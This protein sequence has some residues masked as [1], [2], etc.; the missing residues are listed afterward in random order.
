MS[1]IIQPR[2]MITKYP[3][4]M[5]VLQTEVGV[6]AAFR[7]G[8]D[9]STTIEMFNGLWDTGATGSAISKIVVDQLGLKPISK[10]KVFNVHGSKDCDVFLI[11][12]ILPSGIS[13]N[14]LSA[15]EGNFGDGIGVLIGMDVISKGD[16]SIS[17]FSNKTTFSFRIPS[18]EHIEL[19][20]NP[21][22]PIAPKT[23]ELYPGTLPN[24]RCPCKSGKK[25][26]NCCKTTSPVVAF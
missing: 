4:I 16:F 19:Q 24:N 5:R 12:V 20:S 3:A 23:I 2:S 9:P 11:N 18:S 1:Q 17:N 7:P 15:T 21:I 14:G 6:S 25:Y 22:I 10:I 8:I 26:K 13:V